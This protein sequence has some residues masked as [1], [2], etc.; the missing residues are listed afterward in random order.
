MRKASR[1]VLLIV[2]LLASGCGHTFYHPLYPILERPDRPGLE[3][4]SG[5]EIGKMSPEARKAV[6]GNF[7]KLLDYSKKLEIAIDTYNAYAK[8]Q[9]KTLGGEKEK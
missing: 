6:V 2:L 7:D 1:V 9:N 5:E 4:I 3:N 8:K